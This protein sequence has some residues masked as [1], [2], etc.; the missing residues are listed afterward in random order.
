MECNVFGL[1][2]EWL[3][4]AEE[5]WSQPLQMKNI[6]CLTTLKKQ[7]N[8]QKPT[9]ALY[10]HHSQQSLKGSPQGLGNVESLIF[11]NSSE[12]FF[13][14]PQDSLIDLIIYSFCS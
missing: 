6:L 4:L 11:P 7:T 3:Q 9:K 12:C 2:R 8:K 14:L 1:C 10:F 13:S 5:E